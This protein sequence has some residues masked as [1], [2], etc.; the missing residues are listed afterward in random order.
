MYQ[1]VDLLTLTYK[2]FACMPVQ[3][4][5]FS[6]QPPPHSDQYSKYHKFQVKLTSVTISCKR[7]PRF[8]I[9]G[10]CLV[11]AWLY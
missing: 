3:L 10:G 8:D 2:I 5:L 4:N 11:E 6:K 9:L 7:I 1:E